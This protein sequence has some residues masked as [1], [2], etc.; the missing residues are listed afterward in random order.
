MKSEI[1]PREQRLLEKQKVDAELTKAR[2]ALAKL[3]CER[4]AIA[5]GLRKG[6]LIKRFDVKLQLAFGLTTLRQRLMS[7]CRA[8]PPR[9]VDQNEHAIGQIIDAEVRSAL[10]DIAAWPGKLGRPNW[11]KEIDAD[12]MPAPEVSGNGA[13][14]G[15][16][17]GA[18]KRER[19]NAKRRAKYA[20]AKEG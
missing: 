16:A 7:F 3:R 14:D 9:L 2:T 18:V 20:K 19:A 17:E 8:L 10:S 13:G 1:H 15:V 6:E 12:L 4:D 5:I 11:D